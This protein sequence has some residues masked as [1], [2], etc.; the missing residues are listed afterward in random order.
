MGQV[1]GDWV[2]VGDSR[3]EVEEECGIGVEVLGCTVE[4]ITCKGIRIGTEDEF[5][6]L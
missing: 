4:G 2:S 5:V 1:E 6:E 3:E